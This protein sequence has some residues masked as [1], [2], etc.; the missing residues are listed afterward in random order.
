MTVNSKTEVSG[1][2]RQVVSVDAYTL[3]ADVSEALGGTGSAPTPHDYFDLSLATC[4]A[5][6]ATMY[7]KRK[8]FLLERVEASVERDAS[9]EREGAYVLR[10]RLAFFGGLSDAEKLKLH[11]IATHCPIHKLMTTSTV[12]I[13]TSPLETA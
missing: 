1:G 10:L 12:E 11:D 2:Y 4:K 9:R 3:H 5:L 6:T 13:E 8:G 7:A